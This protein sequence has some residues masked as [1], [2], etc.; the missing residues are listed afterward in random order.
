MAQPLSPPMEDYLEV[1]GTLCREQTVARVK[2]IARH[3]GVSNPSVVR[4]LQTL[5]SRRLVVQEPYG[6]VRLTPEGERAAREI[7]D[8][9]EML[10]D[11][12][13]NI[14]GLDPE[15]ASRDACRLEHAVS[16]ETVR[17]MQAAAVFLK[18]EV[19]PDLQWRREFGQYYAKRARRTS[20]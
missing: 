13:E 9:H 14:L 8:K 19:H 18:S 3:M 16:P 15:T 20:P 12:L 1:I 11:F 17:R 5:K 10:A 4:A 6:F 2:D 7:L